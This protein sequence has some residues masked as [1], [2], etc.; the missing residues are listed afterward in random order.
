MKKRDTQLM[1]LGAGVIGYFLW[2]QQR[3]RAREE[4]NLLAMDAAAAD[5]DARYR[6]QWD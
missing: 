4:S 6:A 5:A 1:W 2:K 3:D